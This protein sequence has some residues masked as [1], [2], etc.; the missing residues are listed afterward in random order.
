MKKI[1]V[2]LIACL[3]GCSD[4]LEEDPKG[5]VLGSFALK[6]IDG[7][8]AALTGAYKPWGNTWTSGFNTAAI[9]GVVMGSDDLT[10]HKGSNKASFREFDQF[11][12]TSLNDRMMVI[13]YG[14]YKAIQGANNIIANYETLL[15]EDEARVKQIAGEAY[16]IRA[17]SYFW[18]VRLWGKIPLITKA[19]VTEDV[20]KIG[21]SEPIDIYSLIVSDL[22]QAEQF[23][24]PTKRAPGRS[25]RGSAKA[26]L[27]DVYL[28]MGGWPLNDASSYA[29]AAAKA[30]EVI[31]EKATY[32]FDL[33]PDLNTLWNGEPSAGNPNGTPEEVFSMHHCGSCQWFTS[34]AVFGNA[35]M[36]A[37]E[38][39]WDDYFTEIKFF[40]DFPAGVRKDVT[41]STT[42]A[43]G[44]I[45]WQDLATQH[46]YYK[47]FRLKNDELT[48]QTSMQ[49]TLIR[50]AHVLLI[51]AEAQ[52]QATGS[53]D[54]DAYNAVNAIRQRAGLAPLSGLSNTDF[55][56][57]VVQERAWEFAGEYTR[58]FDLVRLEMV[59]SANANKDANDIPVSGAITK[60][61][62]WL[63]IPAADVSINPNIGG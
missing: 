30:K 5:Q 63:P 51:Y 24:S 33:V 59:E 57:A 37:E 27:A 41:F 56:K 29:K 3:F 11:A 10:T 61:K 26:L 58:W 2:V 42:F 4:L 6:N 13:W 15:S 53:A 54:S 50:Y 20:L 46:P 39:G 18:L 7:L 47:K 32:G 45:S 9:N 17:Y 44:T 35:T 12:V 25:S 60:S 16:F 48:W 1:F 28:T 22:E 40:N 43:G 55:I 14:C 8:E 38:N 49:L 31:S 19:E 23:L 34:N 36:P 21:L 62:Y 52:A